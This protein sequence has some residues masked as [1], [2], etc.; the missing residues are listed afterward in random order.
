MADLTHSVRQKLKAGELHTKALRMAEVLEAI[1]ETKREQKATAQRAKAKIDEL[2]SELERLTQVISSGHEWI[3]VACREQIDERL[4]RVNIIR[5]DTGETVD[6]RPMTP[7][8]H[9]RSRQ[10]ELPGV[11]GDGSDDSE[12]TSK[13]RA[14]AEAA[15]ESD[16]PIDLE[17][18]PCPSC[19][20]FVPVNE[21]CANCHDSDDG[22]T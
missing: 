15:D 22:E 12:F 21:A 7:D 10:G 16:D 17:V 1:D 8:E 3:D 20:E 2:K 14:A 11:E 4:A 19:G 18:S 5:K 9:H 13:A 6:Y